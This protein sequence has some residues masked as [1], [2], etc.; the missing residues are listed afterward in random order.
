[1]ADHALQAAYEALANRLRGT[2]ETWGSN[3][4]VSWLKSST[5]YPYVLYFW[6]GGGE[7][8]I[9][10]YRHAEYRI[11]VVCISNKLNDATTGAARISDLLREKGKQ[12]SP[13]D[14]LTG[15]SDWDILTVTEEDTIYLVENT[16]D[17][18]KSY[19][20]GAYY[21]FFMQAT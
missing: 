5:P 2:G 3:A 17:T 7:R 15:S 18:I 12:T 10:G 6:A 14:Y 8:Q 21:R 1:M 19:R 11:A 9:N 4:R 13:A 20:V 16:P